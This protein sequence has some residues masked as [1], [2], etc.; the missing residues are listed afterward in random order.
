VAEHTCPDCGYDMKDNLSCPNCQAARIGLAESLAGPHPPPCTVDRLKKLYGKDACGVTTEEVLRHA[1]ARRRTQRIVTVVW[2][3]V[4]AISL[5]VCYFSDEV[6]VTIIV[7]STLAF[8]AFTF[9]SSH[10]PICD[11]PVRLGDYSCP[12]CGFTFSGP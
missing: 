1:R 2:L 10:C 9:R 4:C 3:V 12:R 8:L 11:A 6:G 7:L 5:A